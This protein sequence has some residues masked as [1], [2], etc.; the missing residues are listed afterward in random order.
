MQEKI[1]VVATDE[2]YIQ[3]CKYSKYKV[4]QTGVATSNVIEKLKDLDKNIKIINVGF[5]GSNSLPVGSIV[6]VKNSYLYHPNVEIKG[7]QYV[8]NGD[9]DCY[10][11]HD[12]VLQTPIKEPVIFDMELNAICAFGFEV[13]SYKIVS[14]NLS[15]TDYEKAEAREV[16]LSECFKKVFEIIEE[17]K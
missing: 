12:F 2:E 8:L 3:A 14:D 1:V 9:V 16:D 17:Q 6:K 5:V 13:E 11:S 15:L 7:K 4:I 10:T